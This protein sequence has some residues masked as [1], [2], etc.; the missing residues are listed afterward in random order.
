MRALSVFPGLARA[1]YR[2]DEQGRAIVQARTPDGGMTLET[3]ALSP[4]A[5]RAR[6]VTP[7]DVA[8]ER[9]DGR[10]RAHKLVYLSDHDAPHARLVLAFLHA[11]G[12]LEATLAGYPAAG[13]DPAGIAAAFPAA[14]DLSARLEAAWRALAPRLPLIPGGTP[15]R[16]AYVAIAGEP[17]IDGYPLGT[18]GA[19]APLI[20]LQPFLWVGAP[21][22]LRY[23]RALGFQTF[24]RVLDERYDAPDA[25]AARLV[26]LF[27]QI[28]GLGARDGAALRNLQADCLPELL[29]NRA[30]VI[31]G[32]HQL[33]RL[34][35]E[36]E[37]EYGD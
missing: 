24:G 9:R 22:T 35:E 29:H 10:L 23:L 2:A 6:Y 25:L 11:A 1:T 3:V 12:C 7:D 28:E 14:P 37:S 33:D 5:F 13:A 4:D 16:D 36:L 30:H 20:N 21:D 17:T 26:R 19:L 31:E 8:A 32:R 34:L 27:G 18:D 15:Q